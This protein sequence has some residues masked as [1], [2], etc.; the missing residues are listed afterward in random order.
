VLIIGYQDKGKSSK[1][2]LKKVSESVA[3][4]KTSCIFAPRF[5]KKKIDTDVLKKNIAKVIAE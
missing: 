5:K 2:N 4:I 3:R 1:N